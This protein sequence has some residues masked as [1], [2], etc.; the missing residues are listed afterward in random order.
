M[1]A[2]IIAQHT[3][4]QASYDWI[5][6]VA[7]ILLVVVIALGLMTLFSR[8]TS[9]SRGGVQEPPD[10]RTRGNPPFESIERDA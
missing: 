7:V 6:I 5:W 2:L 3:D 4:S 1:A 9:K 10:S 8:T